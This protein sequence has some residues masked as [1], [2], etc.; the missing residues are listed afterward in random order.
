MDNIEDQQ[1]FF[2]DILDG[3]WIYKP[4]NLYR[5]KRVR[6]ISDTEKFKQDFIEKQKILNFNLNENL[7]IFILKKKTLSAG[8]QNLISKRSNKFSLRQKPVDNKVTLLQNINNLKIPQQKTSIK[9]PV[10]TRGFSNSKRLSQFQTSKM[11]MSKENDEPTKD[12]VFKYKC[13]SSKAIFQKYIEK[14][15]LYENRKCELR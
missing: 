1:L 3:I 7:P 9:L 8:N 5:N 14:P 11:Q 15:F 12:Y 6:L 13:L 10:I 4:M 2:Q